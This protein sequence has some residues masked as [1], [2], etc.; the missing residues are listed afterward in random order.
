MMQ[1]R[2]PST[3]RLPAAN[4]LAG[5]NLADVDST[6]KAQIGDID[7][8]VSI[9][10]TSQLPWT[11][12]PSDATK[13]LNGITQFDRGGL[14]KAL[15]DFINGNAA[16][17]K[18]VDFAAAWTNATFGGGTSIKG[19]VADLVN[20][21]PH[22]AAEMF[23]GAELLDENR[24]GGPT[25]VFVAVL[26][27]ATDDRD[28]NDRGTAN[29]NHFWLPTAAANA[30]FAIEKI[31]DLYVLFTGNDAGDFEANNLHK[32]QIGQSAAQ[33]A[34]AR[35]AV[36]GATALPAGSSSRKMV[37]PATATVRPSPMMRR[38]GTV[39]IELP[40]TARRPRQRTSASQS[41]LAISIMVPMARCRRSRQAAS[42]M[43]SQH[44]PT[45]QQEPSANI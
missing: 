20:A 45:R 15:E 11:V 34:A 42:H 35:K 13:K 2:C 12:D 31:G 44:L 7:T 21:Q 4:I 26:N 40:M 41:L 27:G 32:L 9:N 33:P 30:G 43:P 39:R 36:G 18:A 1:E 25:K 29:Q 23:S 38:S 3:R 19:R 37:I 28:G 24:D 10:G 5:I 14:W 8:A 22:L 16:A 6:L 17:A